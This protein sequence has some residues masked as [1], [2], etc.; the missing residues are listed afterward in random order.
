[1]SVIRWGWR[2]LASSLIEEMRMKVVVQ[3]IALLVF[4]SAVISARS[5]T[6]YSTTWENDVVPVL[7]AVKRSSSPQL[8]QPL[9]VPLT[10]IQGA[11]S[12][13]AGIFLF[14][15]SLSQLSLQQCFE[16]HTR[17]EIE[18]T[19]KAWFNCFKMLKMW[20]DVGSWFNRLNRFVGSGF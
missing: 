17:H 15:P 4:V 19:F 7:L 9:M 5:E 11:A 2:S 13:G 14:S 12:K 8:P 1:M 16:N 6:N 18:E 20:Y 10:L 3:L